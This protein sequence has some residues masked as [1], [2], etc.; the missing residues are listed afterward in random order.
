[1]GLAKSSRMGTLRTHTSR[2]A[3]RS[4]ERVLT[5]SHQPSFMQASFNLRSPI[6]L[7]FQPSSQRN[8]LNLL[9]NSLLFH[10]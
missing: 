9:F 8:V 1:M 5:K 4:R 10:A 6:T 3:R 2:E 7:I